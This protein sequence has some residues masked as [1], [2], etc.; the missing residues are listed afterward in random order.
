MF[1]LQ[2]PFLVAGVYVLNLWTDLFSP[3]FVLAQK[4]ASQSTRFNDLC[5]EVNKSS[6]LD[7]NVLKALTSVERG[8]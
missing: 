2:P 6:V 3:F 1:L 5:N 4:Q 7:F 8:R